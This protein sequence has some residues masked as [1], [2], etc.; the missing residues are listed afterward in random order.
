ML[1][2]SKCKFPLEDMTDGC[3]QCKH[4]KTKLTTWDPGEGDNS[5]LGDMHSYQK[6]LR[7]HRIH[8]EKVHQNMLRKAADTYDPKLVE[9]LVKMS[10]AAIDLGKMVRLIQND[11]K[12]MF[13]QMKPAEHNRLLAKV[14]ASLQPAARLEI[15][16]MADDPSIGETPVLEPYRPGGN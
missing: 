6:L 3:K 14:L 13:A 15:L 16:K 7:N 2:C 9:S 1:L 8:L 10:K 12:R 5:V 4:F 11:T